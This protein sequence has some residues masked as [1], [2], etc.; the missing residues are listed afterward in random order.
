[1]IPFGRIRRT[2]D[3]C[4]P[5]TERTSARTGGCGNPISECWDLFGTSDDS[6]MEAYKLDGRTEGLSWNPP[7]LSFDIERHGGVAKGVRLQKNIP[8]K[9]T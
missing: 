2:E 5:T 3:V 8:G 6:S 4:A 9:S 7:I 1:M